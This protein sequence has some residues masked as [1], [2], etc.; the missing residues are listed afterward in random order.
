M[1]RDNVL[2]YFLGGREILFMPKANQ[3][4]LGGSVPLRNPH[5]QASGSL[6]V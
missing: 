2:S 6:I 5:P 1:G 3:V 4:L